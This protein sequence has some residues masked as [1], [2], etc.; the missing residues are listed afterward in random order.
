MLID[1]R[2][3]SEIIGKAIDAK[4]REKHG[5]QS[6]YIRHVDD[7]FIGADDHDEAAQLL[8]GIRDAIRYFQLDLNDS[9]TSVVPTNLDLEPF[10]PVQ[11]RRE[12]EEFSN[13]N[14]KASG[15]SIGHDFVYFLDEVVRI[16]N[17]EKDDGVIKYSLRKMDDYKI[18][19]NYWHLVEPFL[20]KAAINFSH[21][22]D[23]ISRIASW[24]HRTS[25]LDTNL[26]AKVISKSVLKQANSGH[27]SQ[28]CW[29]LWLAK[30]AQIP[31]EL[32]ALEVILERCGSLTATLALDVF[33][34][35]PH[36]YAFPKAKLLDK[37]DDRPMLGEN[38]LLAYEADRLFGFKL[39]T[40]NLIG[41]PLFE[42]L[43][44][45]DTE[46]YDRDAIPNAFKDEV[47]PSEVNSAL[48]DVISYY[49]DDHEEDE[50]PDRDTDPVPLVGI[51]VHALFRVALRVVA[52]LSVV[53][54]VLIP[55]LNRIRYTDIQS[56]N[57]RTENPNTNAHVPLGLKVA[58]KSASSR[59]TDMALPNSSAST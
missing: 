4:F 37:F 47:D 11:I 7:I 22:W 41:N 21:C 34:S 13:A 42:D 15:N 1:S 39:K 55:L 57:S 45:N 56:K 35:I 32:A 16:A 25:G 9:K 14:P 18:W 44:N 17:S 3:S 54:H 2:Y 23:Y 12:I 33:Q 28:V 19:E 52:L 46:F 5:D 30:E 36:T 40:K 26:W 59:S 43:Y 10:W 49:D 20:V 50:E 53:T 29:A 58:S 48:D 27:D 6:I 24:R 38:W 8:T 31:I 51:D